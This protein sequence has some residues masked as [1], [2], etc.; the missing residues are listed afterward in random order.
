ML[1]TAAALTV[2][3]LAAIVRGYSGFGFSLIAITGLALI[4]PVSSIVPAIF[5]MEIAAT[6]H[7]LPSIWKDIHWRSLLPLIIGCLLATPLGLLALAYVSPEYMQIALGIFVLAAVALMLRGFKLNAV[8][9]TAAAVA[10][11]GAAGFFNGAFGIAGPPVI[12]F[13]FS[14]PA[15]NAVGRASIAAFFFFTDVIG[16]SYAAPI[17]LLST[18]TLWRAALFL[19][20]LLAGVWVGSRSFKA[21]DQ[22]QFRRWMLLLLAAM[23][24]LLLAKALWPAG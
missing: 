23:A 21:A 3:F 14:S 15:G 20:A 19:P 9:G 13:Y 4:Y 12:L 7:M 10:A 22:E 1:A 5:L 8:P 24:I 16:L 2:I 6:L 17:G 18:N 11:G